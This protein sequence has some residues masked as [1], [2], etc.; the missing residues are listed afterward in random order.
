MFSH[1]ALKEIEAGEMELHKAE[2]EEIV[3]TNGKSW[4]CPTYVRKLPPCRFECPSSE[5]IRGY[6]TFIAQ[7]QLLKRDQDAAL[8]EAWRILTDKNPMPGVHGRICPHPCEKGCNRSHKEDGAVAIN[9]MERFVGDWGIARKLKL[10]RLTDK[11]KDK[12]VAVVGSGPSGLSCAYQLA[13]RGY[14]VTLFEAFAEAGGM[15]RYGIP[16]YRLPR[17]VLDAEIQNILD[18]GVDLKVNT[19]IGKDILWDKFRKD[20][21]AV[22]LAAGAHKGSELGVPGEDAANVFTAASYLNRVNS[23]AKVEIGKQVVVVGGG[24]SAVDAA[25]TSLRVALAT[26]DAE[27]RAFAR[28][29]HTETDSAGKA[30]LDSARV[31]ERLGAQVTILYRR[32]REEMPAI[33]R[34]V[35]E[36]V[37]EGVSIEYLTAPVEV[38][39]DNGRATAIKLIRMKL[40]EPD[41]SGRRS[42]VPVEGSEYTL[43]L[44]TLIVGIGQKPDLSGGLEALAGK[45]GFVK[46]DKDSHHTPE[47]GVFAGGDVLG[48]GISTRS[49]GEGRKAA[50]AIDEFLQGRTARNKPRARVVREKSLILNH[51]PAAPRHEEQSIGTDVAEIGF[52]ELYQAISKDDAVAE[53]KRCMSCGLCF[54]CDQCRVFCPYEAIRKDM[55]AP[56]GQVM[57]TD[58]TKCVGCHICAEVC[59]CGYIEMGMGL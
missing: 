51:Y 29:D 21:D 39:R 34:D 27:T 15:L 50:L 28:E 41:K 32:T 31:A 2:P 25:R 14:R 53:A 58:Y 22:Y 42:P 56:Q 13:R 40:G 54:A 4:K 48:L 57:F 43:P 59:P 52:R 3:V 30:A 37:A 12:K 55:K 10:T 11:M 6:L 26:D 1:T 24:D 45:D 47:K 7:A 16:S 19:R 17:D 44:T 18:V 5:D 49:V 8:D 35:D 46:V 23:G 20:Y 36:A 38:I 33:D 9:N